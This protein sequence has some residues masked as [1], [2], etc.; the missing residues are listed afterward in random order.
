MI[1]LIAKLNYIVHK[2]Y[3]TEY[4]RL[5]LGLEPVTYYRLTLPRSWSGRTSD[6]QTGAELLKQCRRQTLGKNISILITRRHMKH[7]NLTRNNQIT[8]KMNINLNVFGTLML[9]W[10]AGQING[11]YI[12]TVNKRSGR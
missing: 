6:A 4:S 12:I 5:G 9:N 2:Y 1:L 7:S 3:S 11:T 8:N 10:I